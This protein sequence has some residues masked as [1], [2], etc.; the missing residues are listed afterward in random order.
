M[1]AITTAKTDGKKKLLKGDFTTHWFVTV[2]Q[3]GKDTFEDCPE[4]WKKKYTRCWGYTD[5]F[6]DAEKAVLENY[7]DIHET[8]YQW[9][10]I[11][12]HVMDVFAIGT[13]LFQWYHWNKEKEGYERCRQPDWAKGVVHWGIG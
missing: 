2:V 5:K 1:T 7:T 4:I 10:I 3:T 11:E 12:E 8:C 9:V 6:E 13:G